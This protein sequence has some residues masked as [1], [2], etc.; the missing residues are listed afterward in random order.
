MEKIEE[1]THFTPKFNSDGLI[2]AIVQNRA[3]QSVLMFAWMNEAALSKTRQTGLVHFF[4]RSR[5][6]LWLKGESSGEKFRVSS[7][8]VDCDQD[9]LLVTV[10]PEK[11]G[12]ACH[13]GRRSCFYR[14]LSGNMLEKV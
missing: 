3:D 5:N 12:T 2:P 11:T 14:E 1:T 10:T 6:S 7:I 4:S 9:C 8:R 13:T